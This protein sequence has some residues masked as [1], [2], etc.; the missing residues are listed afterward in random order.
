MVDRFPRDLQYVKFSAYGFLKNLRFFEPFMVLFLLDQGATL[1]E[2]G[3]LFAF[4][5]IAVNILEI[6]TGALA[7]ALGRRRTMAASFVSYILSYILFWTGHQIG[8]FFVAMLFFSFGEAFRTGTH[9]AMIFTYLRIKG[10][11]HHRTDYYGHTRAWSQ[12]GSAV[13]SIIAALIVFAA[14]TYRPV[15]LFSMIPYVLDLAL[16]LSYPRELDGKASGLRLADIGSSFRELWVSIV[17]TAR[18]P[19]TFRTVLSAASFAGYYKGV[20]DYLQP[21][22]AVLALSLPLASELETEQ[23]KAIV[24][25]VVYTLLYLATAVASS[26]AGR[27]AARLRTPE[28]ALNVHLLAGLGV[29]VAVGVAATVGATVL[30]VALFVLIYIIENLRQ[31]V[32]VAVVSSRVPE[33]VL[34]TVLSAESQFQSLFAALVAFGVGAVASLLDS[35]AGPGV[36]AVSIVWLLA[37]PLLRVRAPKEGSAPA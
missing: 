15:F 37:Y 21:M 2:V 22:I 3:A 23:R 12:T 8:I 18:R 11:D 28:R 25:G 9:K 35:G 32:A 24:V 19:G 7:D 5:E 20:K 14:R 17:E 10:I 29:G 16:M 36:A 30:P 6:P 4:R 27:V 1:F 26:R 34:A 31:P 33:G 13:S